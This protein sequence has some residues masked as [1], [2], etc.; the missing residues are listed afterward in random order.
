MSSANLLRVHSI[1]AVYIIDENIKRHQ[2]QYRPLRDTTHH[3][4]PF[5]HQAL[6]HYPLAVT[7][8]DEIEETVP[9]HSGVGKELPWAHLE[10]EDEKSYV[11][12]EVLGLCS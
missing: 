11:L 9:W 8:K 2:S 7:F 5:R 6:D 3:Q 12:L 10:N 4:R 1:F